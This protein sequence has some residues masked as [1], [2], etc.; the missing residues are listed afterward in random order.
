MHPYRF[1]NRGRS[2]RALLALLA[3]WGLLVVLMLKI[4]L[5]P[6]IA[7]AVALLTLPTAW[8]YLTDPRSWLT[9]DQD[10]LGWQSARSNDRVALSMIR[11][12]RFDTRL[13]LSVRITLRLVDDRKIRLPHACTPPHRRFETEL[14]ARGIATERHHFALIG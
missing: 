7:G 4:S 6:W 10:H 9:L 13:D 5:S 1:E 8:E 3:V 12:A 11:N 14:K 2:R